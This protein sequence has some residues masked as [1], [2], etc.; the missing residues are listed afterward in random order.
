MGTREDIIKKAL[1]DKLSGGMDIFTADDILTV[2][3]IG[4]DEMTELRE[5]IETEMERLS[6]KKPRH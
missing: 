1:M 3:D 5:S 4:E 2:A 6:R